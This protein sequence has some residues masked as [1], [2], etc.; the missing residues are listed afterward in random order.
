ML[1]SA[2]SLAQPPNLLTPH[3]PFSLLPYPF[4]SKLARPLPHSSSWTFLY[5]P[6]Y[7][8]FNTWQHFT[9]ID[10]QNSRPNP[11][12]FPYFHNPPCP[13]NPAYAILNITNIQVMFGTIQQVYKIA[14]VRASVTP[15]LV[16]NIITILS[17]FVWN[18]FGQ[19][20]SDFNTFLCE[21]CFTYF[22]I[23]KIHPC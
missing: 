16:R 21:N 5:T 10:S 3:A 7:L 12:K 19:K 17:S 1:F 6:F 9:H 22:F 23:P 13:S 15:Q 20:W 18:N 2:I 8:H 14:L 11:P 4:Y